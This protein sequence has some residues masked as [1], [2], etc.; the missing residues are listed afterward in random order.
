MAPSNSDPTTSEADNDPRAG[1]PYRPDG[2]GSVDQAIA[3][4]A[5]SVLEIGRAWMM[6]PATG[7]RAAELGL[8]GPFGFWTSGRAGAIG[9]VDAD[10]VAAAIGFMAPSEVRS[11]WEAR[12]SDITPMSITEAFAES[13]ANWGRQAFASI[14]ET[15]LRRL[16][17]LCNTIAAAALPSTGV[18]FVVW[19]N[20][21]QPDDAAGAATVALNV[22]RELRGGAHL[23]A[24]HAVGLGPHGAI[25]STEDPVRGGVPWAERFGWSAPHPTPD[26][27]RRAEAE[28]L[29]TRICRHAYDALDD[30]ELAEFTALVT[31]ART[32]LDN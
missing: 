18:L 22:L 21:P 11:Y 8:E 29:T 14:P 25:L 32:A 15:D 24:V 20:L 5:K 6:E 10:V 28:A 27:A 17:D 2:W 16:A 26:P 1:G 3:V 4:T 23:T 13:A 31:T 7:A 19:R 30:G 9:E 12:P